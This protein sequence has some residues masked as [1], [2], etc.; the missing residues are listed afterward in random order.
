MTSHEVG[1]LVG[2]VLLP[3]VGREQGV[4]IGE[5]VLDPLQRLGVRRLQGLLHPGEL[6]V[7][8]LPAQHLLDRLEGR[9]RL[10]RAPLVVVQRADGAGDVVGQRVQFQFGEPRVVALGAGQGLPLGGQRLVQ[11][12]PDLVEGAAEIAAPA[13][14]GAQPSDLV[15]QPVQAAAAVEAPAHQIPQGIA[16]VAGRHDI[17][18]D[19][20]DRLADVVRR[21]QRIGPAAPGSVAEPP[22]HPTM[23]MIM[24]PGEVSTHQACTDH[25]RARV[26]GAPRGFKGVVPLAVFTP[27]RRPCD[28]R[29]TPSRSGGSGA[30]PRA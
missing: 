2:R 13:G 24:V 23:I 17:G 18:A 20:V 9:P 21:R 10:V 14:L 22:V 5:H 8:H 30:A 26:V 7:Q 28:R 16:Q 25:A 11:C 19:L 6:G 12:G 4:Q 27:L 3:G 15:G 1:E 29:R